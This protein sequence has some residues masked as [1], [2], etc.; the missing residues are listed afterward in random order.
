MRHSEQEGASRAPGSSL[1]AE[2]PSAPE[3]EA[4]PCDL[5]LAYRIVTLMSSV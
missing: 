3:S 1:A 5:D 2:I 4:F